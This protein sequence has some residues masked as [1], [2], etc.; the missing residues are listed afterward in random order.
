VVAQ[1]ESPNAIVEKTAMGQVYREK[2]ALL[3]FRNRVQV[4]HKSILD[5][6]MLAK[7]VSVSN[8]GMECH[9]HVQQ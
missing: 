3:K 4:G 6:L 8:Q 5:Q 1:S 9:R 2:I 7:A